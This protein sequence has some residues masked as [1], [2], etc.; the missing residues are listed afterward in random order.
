[1]EHNAVTPTTA[2]HGKARIISIPPELTNALRMYIIEQGRKQT[3]T[4]FNCTTRSYQSNFRELKIRMAK[5]NNDP[6]LLSVRLYDLRHYFATITYAKLRDIPLTAD[7]MGHKDYNT[8]A[9]YLHLCKIME[10]FSDEGYIV[11]TAK[12]EKEITELLE[13]GFTKQDE[14]DGIHFYRKRK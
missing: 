9:K 4:I 1:M 13:A 3:D 7:E 11:K 5:R 8:T 2:K 6:S 14:I 12:T 10:L